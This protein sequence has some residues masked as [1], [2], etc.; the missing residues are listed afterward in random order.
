MGYSESN[1]NLADIDWKAAI[2]TPGLPPNMDFAI[3]GTFRQKGCVRIWRVQAT[4]N[5][6][7][8]LAKRTW[9]EKETGDITEVE[10]I[11]EDL[12]PLMAQAVL[13]KLLGE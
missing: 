13:F 9:S 8:Y 5:Y 4:G 6:I 11:Y 3:F 12:P 2:G 7:I 10:E 1:M